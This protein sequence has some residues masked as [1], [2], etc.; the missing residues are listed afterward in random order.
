MFAKAEVSMMD[1]CVKRGHRERLCNGI[2]QL[3]WGMMRYF[4]SG[5]LSSLIHD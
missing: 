2:G 1:V 3:W 4:C 5:P